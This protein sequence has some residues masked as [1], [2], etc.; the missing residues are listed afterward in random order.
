MK[1]L[2]SSLILSA[3]LAA[4][5]QQGQE[6]Y[7]GAEA[8]L[9]QLEAQ[10]SGRAGQGQPNRAA[11]LRAEIQNLEKT[12]A[13]LPPEEAADRWL[14]LLDD[15]LS[16]TPHEL[17][18]EGKGERQDGD[19]AARAPE[20]PDVLSA[21]P[22]SAVWN[23]LGVRLAQKK[24][25]NPGRA[26]FMELLVSVLRGDKAAWKLAFD[27]MVQAAEAEG[28]DGKRALKAF[29]VRAL[30][31]QLEFLTAFGDDLFVRFE[32]YVANR[33]KENAGEAKPDETSAIDILIR[34][35]QPFVQRLEIPDLVRVAG[36]ERA[37]ALL[38]RAMRAGLG[39]LE[40]RGTAT[41]RLAA[42]VALAEIDHLPAPVWGLVESPED[43]PLY[44]ALIR[45]F[46]KKEANDEYE[47][48]SAATVYLAALTTQG[49]TEEA[50]SFFQEE[51]KR[52]SE[53][54]LSVLSKVADPE[55]AGQVLTFFRR[56]LTER[57]EIPAWSHL[58][59][60][61]A[62][63]KESAGA[64]KLAAEVITRP[65]LDSGA[66][67]VILPQLVRGLFAADHQE[68]GI[69]L[70]RELV[71][72]G[73]SGQGKWEPQAVPLPGDGGKRIAPEAFAR[74]GL[75]LRE[76]WRKDPNEYTELCG[77]LAEAGRL[78]GHPEWTAEALGNA[79]AWVESQPMTTESQSGLL[80][81]FAKAA[82]SHQKGALAERLIT[83]RLKYLAG[84]KDE[85]E[86]LDEE[87]ELTESLA[88]LYGQAGRHRDVL[89]LLERS[90]CWAENDLTQVD[91]GLWLPAAHALARAGR[92]EEA[93]RITRR[94]LQ[95][96]P[97]D[98]RGYELWLR[99]GAS[100]PE[101]MVFL[102]TLAAANRFE[103]RPLIWKARLLLDNGR[104]EEAEKTARAA[105]SIDPSDGAGK[106][107]PHARLRRAGGGPGE[108]RRCRHSGGHARRGQRHPQ[109]R[110]GRRLVAG[111]LS[112]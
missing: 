52:H 12:V 13:A 7:Q 22:P 83:A 10:T 75:A 33:E 32:G 77:R 37:S 72:A 82:A 26:A 30:Q 110:G 4:S 51:S 65:D 64:L 1:L 38:A 50:W 71:R 21:L 5:A 48:N 27:H 24:I 3:V 73:Y 18:E 41:K 78:L 25:S 56:L 94:Y 101:I 100:E 93:R 96:H 97:H 90:P 66:A 17:R 28:G 106:G 39:T 43:A 60:L 40:V 67:A 109:I 19:Q 46:P 6:E 70:L 35:Y 55:A 2:V 23:M 31:E 80:W 79:A 99:L 85:E 45:K 68:E 20:L 29:R 111:R 36:E 58:I 62:K 91:P 42:K 63:R 53:L 34:Q 92:L 69:L 49:R 88:G 74:W 59:D 44:T 104:I 47:R 11:G 84:L 95:D 61:S 86:T 98:D 9:R 15:W 105:I 76:S 102:E 108:K 14:A 89:L 87:D 112:G 8:V 16:A 107:R 57:P 103:E 54:D 81:T